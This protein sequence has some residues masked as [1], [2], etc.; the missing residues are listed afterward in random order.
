MKKSVK[1]AVPVILALV[2]FV[3]PLHAETQFTFGS[4]GRVGLSTDEKLAIP[5]ARQIIQNGPRLTQTDYLELD[6][7]FR[8]D[9][10]PE[11]RM[12]L[13]TTFA[14]AGPYAHATGNFET[15]L[16]LRQAYLEIEGLA[17]TR[18]YLWIGSRMERGDDIYLLDAWPL[19]DLNIVGLGLGLRENEGSGGLVLGLN[20]PARPDQIHRTLT[21]DPAFG[22]VSSTDLNR[23]RLISAAHLE[24]RFGGAS[25]TLGVKLKLYGE[26][27]YLPSG[28]RRLTQTYGESEPLPDD[29]GWL[30]GVQVALFNL[31][32]NGH[33]NLWLRYANG[34]AAFDEFTEPF[35]L[36][37]ERRAD[38]ADEVTIA[39]SGNFE[40]RHLGIMYTSHYRFFRDADA[41]DEDFDDRHEWVGVIRGLW[42]LGLFTPGIE[43]SLQIMRPNGLNPRTNEQVVAQSAQI[44]LV[45]AINLGARPGSYARPQIQMIAALS[46]LNQAAQ[47]LFPKRDHR[48]QEAHAWYLGIRAEWWF[49]RGG[50]Y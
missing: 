22:S 11:G 46:M 19:D 42:F 4:Y 2:L 26:A 25:H 24:R 13:V 1:Y 36:N 6:F 5:E 50:G 8:F 29:R 40:S 20:Q 44:A 45:P 41:N 18:S 27:H 14:Y 37:K 30:V 12:Q 3:R 23:Q 47:D 15:P 7:G 32:K 9:P 31:G 17:G 48:A 49:G 43:G 34:L 35:G 39:I 16:S 38:G 28:E 10:S 21:P 33:I